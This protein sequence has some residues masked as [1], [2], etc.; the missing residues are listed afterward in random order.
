MRDPHLNKKQN[1]NKN[2][3]KNK[4][5]NNNKN[6]KK[7]KRPR[8]TH[9]GDIWFTCSFFWKKKKKKKKRFEV[10]DLRTMRTNILSLII[11]NMYFIHYCF[12]QVLE[13]QK[14]SKQLQIRPTNQPSKLKFLV[15]LKVNAT[16]ALCSEMQFICVEFAK[17]DSPQLEDS[18]LPFIVEGVV[19]RDD[20]S[21]APE[22]TRKCRAIGTCRGDKNTILYLKFNHILPLG[23]IDKTE[24]SPR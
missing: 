16:G 17:G 4:N 15:H 14:K 2:K 1:K 6:K 20:T 10:C 12:P 7:K 9:P 24:L 19:G 8:V 23:F 11:A 22:N 21:P 3:T 18:R 5:I 13:G